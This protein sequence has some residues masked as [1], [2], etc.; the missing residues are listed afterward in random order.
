[1]NPDIPLLGDPKKA[2][3]AQFPGNEKSNITV[4]IANLLLNKQRSK[5]T[6]TEVFNFFDYG[7]FLIWLFW[8]QLKTPKPQFF[9]VYKKTAVTAH[10]D[11]LFPYGFQVPP[12]IRDKLPP[13]IV[14]FPCIFSSSGRSLDI[15]YRVYV[16]QFRTGS[17][18][19]SKFYQNPLVVTW[20]P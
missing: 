5:N 10:L 2:N 15:H 9:M 18:Q 13:K 12:K 3:F 14:P 19:W 6:K 7:M 17:E 20:F 11:L 1:M 4:L 16:I 8:I